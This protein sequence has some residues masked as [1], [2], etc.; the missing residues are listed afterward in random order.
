M[1][2]PQD[3]RHKHIDNGL[4]YE[5]PVNFLHAAVNGRGPPACPHPRTPWFLSKVVLFFSHCLQARSVVHAIP[6]AHCVSVP[7]S[8]SPFSQNAL[9]SH[10]DMAISTKSTCSTDKRWTLTRPRGNGNSSWCMGYRLE[11]KSKITETRV[12]SSLFVDSS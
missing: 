9:S 5:G 12:S 3:A 2:V 8:C 6:F 7:D 10:P 1:D 4:L 11:P